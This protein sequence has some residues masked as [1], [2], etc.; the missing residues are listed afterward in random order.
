MIIAVADAPEPPP[1]T[2]ETNGDVVYPLP[3]AVTSI[4]LKEPLTTTDAVAP[5]P[6]PPVIVAAGGDAAS[7]SLPAL[8]IVIPVTAP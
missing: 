5:V 4:L 7:Y 2:I 6:L 1:P 8:L 3:P